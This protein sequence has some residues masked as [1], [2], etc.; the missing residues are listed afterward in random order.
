MLA[1][2]APHL[3]VARTAHAAQKQ[4]I[5]VTLWTHTAQ[6]EKNWFAS[7]WAN[8]AAVN[9]PDYDATLD[10]VP[11]AHGDLHTKALTNMSAGQE[12]PDIMGLTHDFWPK[13]LKGTLVED[14]LAPINDVVADVMD[15]AIGLGSWSKG[16]LFY[17]MR[18]D[19][20]NTAFWYRDDLLQAAGVTT[21]IATWDD[22]L[23][24]GAALKAPARY[25][26]PIVIDQLWFNYLFISQ[27]SG[28]YWT[29]DGRWNLNTPETLEVITYLK[30]GLDEGVFFPVS[31]SD[32]WGSK[33]FTGGEVVGA[34]MPVWYG[35]FVLFPA[36]PDQAGLWRVQNMPR[37]G[38]RGHVSTSVW[39]GT[40]WTFNKNSPN[41]DVIV[42]IA[43]G[44]FYETEA[45]VR[46]NDISKNLPAWTPALADP[47]VQNQTEPY[48]GDQEWKKVFF[49]GLQDSVDGI[50][51]IYD[52]DV[53][54]IADDGWTRFMAGQLGAQEFLDSVDSQLRDLGIPLANE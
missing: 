51:N 5:T 33:F 10:I 27:L 12:L 28:T 2:Y 29:A 1:P 21:P 38:T 20:A 49:E 25:M 11:M 13:F 17:G 9:A 15:N 30:K 36:M 39:G 23:A 8:S 24:A 19:I 35:T 47:R 42:K 22:F 44:M 14:N 45:R 41:L 16:D 46:Y 40:A 4:A 3:P 50:Q 48:L 37:W 18:G 26:M 6:D 53:A 32:F 43:K 7:E 31:Q 34:V 54:P 52:F